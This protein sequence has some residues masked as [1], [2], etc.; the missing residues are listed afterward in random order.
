MISNKTDL[1]WKRA[2]ADKLTGL[3]QE[4]HL[5]V[6]AYARSLGVAYCTL[7]RIERGEGC[8]IDVL[9]HIRQSTGL[10]FDSLLLPLS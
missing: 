9:A 2:L 10:S 8:T 1:P 5:S 3:R 7:W 4:R 6:R